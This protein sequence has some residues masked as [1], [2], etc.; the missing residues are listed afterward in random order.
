MDLAFVV[1]KASP[2]TVHL[3]DIDCE[4]NWIIQTLHTKTI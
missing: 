3:V 2:E 4:S 1:E